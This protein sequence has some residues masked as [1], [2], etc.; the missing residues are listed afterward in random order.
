MEGDPTARTTE[1]RTAR[2]GTVATGRSVFAVSS[3][4]SEQTAMQLLAGAGASPAD[5]ERSVLGPDHAPPRV[6]ANFTFLAQSPEAQ[7][8][9]AIATLG[10]AERVGHERVGS[11]ATTASHATPPPVQPQAPQPAVPA[12]DRAV[13][14]ATDCAARFVC[15]QF[16]A[17]LDDVTGPECAL[18]TLALQDIDATVRDVQQ[19]LQYR[20]GLTQC[21]HSLSPPLLPPSLSLSLSVCVCEREREHTR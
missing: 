2:S 11:V 19:L 15:T 6:P 12:I 5:R 7:E 18:N 14:P 9:I 16:M 20:P 1:V 8:N 21:M 13:S 4:E 10:A 17:Q 3:T